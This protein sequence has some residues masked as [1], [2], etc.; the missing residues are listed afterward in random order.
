MAKKIYKPTN[1]VRTS[2]NT[3]RAHL[4]NTSRINKGTRY[5][6]QRVVNVVGARKNVAYHKE[7]MLLCKQEEAGFQLNAEYGENLNKMKEKGDACI[8][9]GYSTQSRV[10]RMALGHVSF[11]PVPQCLTTALELD[12]LS[13]GPQ[14]QENVPQIAETVTTSNELVLLFSLMFD[15]LLNRT[16]PVVSKSSAVN[17]ADAPDKRQ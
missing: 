2:L 12:S 4:D 1:N 5:D 17:A 9:V 7:K 16:T 11:N 10:Y 14:S 8:F 15:E 6:N 3:S 13:P